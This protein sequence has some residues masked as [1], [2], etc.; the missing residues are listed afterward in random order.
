MN[1]KVGYVSFLWIKFIFL[2]LKV[3][4]KKI[5]L[6]IFRCFKIYFVKK[7]KKFHKNCMHSGCFLQKGH[8]IDPKTL[9]S[10]QKFLT[11]CRDKVRSSTLPNIIG[12]AEKSRDTLWVSSI[13]DLNLSLYI[14]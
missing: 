11:H 6:K 12:R 4:L 13:N 8:K 2:D 14:F 9:V 10:Y 5:N 7:A 3:F 1:L